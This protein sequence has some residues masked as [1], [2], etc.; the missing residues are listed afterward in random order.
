MP[1]FSKEERI[2]KKKEF[3]SVFKARKSVH[4]K[5]F[6]LKCKEGEKTKIGLT[7]SAKVGKAHVRNRIKR[8]LREYFRLNKDKFPS[9]SAVI[10]AKTGAGELSNSEIREEIGALIKIWQRKYPF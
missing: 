4:F 2:L 9:G 8:V 6:F 1:K 10:V 5:N 7:V 3:D